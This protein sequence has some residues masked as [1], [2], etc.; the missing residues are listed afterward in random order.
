M[1]IYI[2]TNGAWQAGEDVATPIL[3][4]VKQLMETKT[5]CGIQFIQFGT[6]PQGLSQLQ[7]LDKELR[8]LMKS[9]DTEP[10]TGNV[11]KMILGSID[12]FFRSD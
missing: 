6:D 5:E 2:L 10:S 4:R 9:V 7:H 8:L 12:E 1:S 3:S 11:W